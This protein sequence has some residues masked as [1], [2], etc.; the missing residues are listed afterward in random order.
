MSNN[1]CEYYKEVT[2]IGAYCTAS[3]CIYD[4]YQKDLGIGFGKICSADG[5][6]EKIFADKERKNKLESLTA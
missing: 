6:L 2:G 1:L 4:K 3:A 5:N